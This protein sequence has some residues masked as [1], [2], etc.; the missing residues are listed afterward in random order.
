VPGVAGPGALVEANSE[1]FLFDCGRCVVPRMA[2]IGL[3]PSAVTCVAR[4]ALSLN[5][6]TVRINIH[7][8]YYNFFQI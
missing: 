7:I 2:Q 4:A 3:M 6:T 8:A 5:S 1:W